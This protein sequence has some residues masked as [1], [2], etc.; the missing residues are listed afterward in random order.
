MEKQYNKGSLVSKIFHGMKKIVKKKKPTCQASGCYNLC[1]SRKDVYC[2]NCIKYP[3]PVQNTYIPPVTVTQPAVNVN[4]SIVNA[5]P[6]TPPPPPVTVNPTTTTPPPVIVNPT[7]PPPK[8]TQVF[9]NSVIKKTEMKLLK[10]G[11]P[12]YKDA[13]QSFCLGLPNNT[14]LGIFKLNMPT[15]L[16]KAHD[17]YKV[18]YSYPNVRAFHGTKC[19]C[20]PQRFVSNP[21]AEFC[22]SGCGACGI[23]Q[24]GNKIRFSGDGKLWFAN[25]SSVSLGYCSY[26]YHA[27]YGYGKNGTY[28]TTANT[29]FIV[30]LITNLP[31]PVYILD[32]E[33]SAIPKY[34]VIFQ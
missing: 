21:K 5:K 34:L 31:G 11:D 20:G 33:A 32:S 17:D 15:H 14:I 22:K 2:T 27:S 1:A 9:S 4:Q 7:P 13:L 8:L 29:M 24:D 12:E 18:K 28:G 16:V 10:T 26:G 23:A 19:V 30:D 25:N 3:P 6:T